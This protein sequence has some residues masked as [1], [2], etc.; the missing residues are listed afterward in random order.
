MKKFLFAA[1]L[2][3]SAI[4][5]SMIAPTDARAE[6][7]AAIHSS[8][9]TNSDTGATVTPD[10]SYAAGNV[11]H[12]ESTGATTATSTTGT[13]PGTA[14]VTIDAN[15]NVS[16]QTGVKDGD[17]QAHAGHDASDASKIDHS[18]ESKTGTMKVRAMGATGMLSMDEIKEVQENL[19]SAGYNV[20]V[21]G[22][23]GESTRTALK[24]YQKAKKLNVTGEVD[25]DTRASFDAN[26][27]A[28]GNN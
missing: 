1:L 10:N 18:M 17:D 11:Q 16:A 3:G 13:A 8:T 2:C 7:E 23:Y 6:G 12:N 21:D 15:N 19:K 9:Q 20:T 14:S 24:E 27:D 5:F 25:A 26:K 22:E 4:G 28:S